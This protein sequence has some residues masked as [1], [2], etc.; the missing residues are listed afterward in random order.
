[1]IPFPRIHAHAHGHGHGHG[2]GHVS[3]C[4]VYGNRVGVRSSL[5]PEV[6]LTS[7]SNFPCA[8]YMPAPTCVRVRVY[9]VMIETYE[10]KLS[11]AE[12]TPL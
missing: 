1:M 12:A 8:R 9:G 10:E 6:A 7:S 11:N 5:Q 3:H 2:H 4:H